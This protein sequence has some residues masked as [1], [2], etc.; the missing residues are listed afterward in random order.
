[1]DPDLYWSSGYN[2]ATCFQI[3]LIVP[4]VTKQWNSLS[5]TMIML[6]EFYGR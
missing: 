5:G 1:M 3:H 6:M 2:D 4:S